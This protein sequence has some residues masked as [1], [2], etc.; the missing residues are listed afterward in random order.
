MNDEKLTRIVEAVT[1]QL[2]EAKGDEKVFGLIQ[3]KK[4]IAAVEAKAKTMGLSVVVAVSNDAGRPIAIECMD[5]SYI[6]SYD[7]A[8]NKAYTVV[9]LK[10]STKKLSPLAKPEGSLYGIQ[11]TNNGQIV[12]F[13]GGDPLIYHGKIVGGLGVSGGSEEQDIL[14]SEYGASILDDIMNEN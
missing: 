11:F 5:N 4:L 13:G 12:V 8:L 2:S 10:M 9:A 14:L 1:K 6:A 3:A 7:I